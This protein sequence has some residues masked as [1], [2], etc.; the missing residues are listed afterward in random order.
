[1]LFS[2]IPNFKST[3]KYAKKTKA[4]K[5]TAIAAKHKRAHQIRNGHTYHTFKNYHQKPLHFKGVGFLDQIG[6]Y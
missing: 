1:M 2:L 3:A 5:N 4:N 6:K